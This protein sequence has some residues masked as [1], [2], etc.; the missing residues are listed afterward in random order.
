MAILEP[1]QLAGS[2][3]SKTTLHNEDF[4]KEKGIKIGDYVIIQK[5][6]DVIPEV[7]KCIEEKRTGEEKEFSMPEVCPVCGA[8]AIR[9]NNEAIRR[10][11][12]IE[13]PARKFRNIVHFAS[14]AGMNIEGLGYAIIEQL[15]AKDLLKGIEDI[16]YLKK[17]DIASLKKSGDKFATNLI[18]AINESKKNNLDKLISALG[19]RHVG[20]K[21]ARI[22][23]REY[24]TMNKLMKANAVNLSLVDEIGVVTANSITEFFQQEQ[25]IELIE[26]LKGAG[27]NMKNI[28]DEVIDDRFAGMTFVLTGTLEK[29][30]RDEASE[31]ISKFGGKTSSSVSKKTTYVLAG[32][33]AGSKLTKAE[34]LGVKIIDE[35][36]FEEM[37]G[38][39]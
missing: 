12:G 35:N 18:N 24:G 32:Q 9:E 5:A 26:K 30:T 36:E 6:G 15:I 33:D 29:Y 8:P 25:T 23:A 31:I 34:S 20:A 1:V 16:Y 38:K 7:V 17:E 27:V 2:T 28:E 37:I 11:I 4:I 22:L 21:A 39:M 19:I 10:C 3:I 13:C 14:K